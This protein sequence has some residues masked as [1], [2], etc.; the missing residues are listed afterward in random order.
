MTLTADELVELIADR[1]DPDFIVEILDI[2]SERLL[3]AF[4]DD[5][6]DNQDKFD[7]W[8]NEDEN[9]EDETS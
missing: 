3:Y 9:G 1:Y 2:T 6:L 7:L 8:E 4:L 5:V